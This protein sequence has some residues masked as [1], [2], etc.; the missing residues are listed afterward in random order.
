[1]GAFTPFKRR[2]NDFKYTP[3]YY[4]PAKE[5]REER[6]EEMFGRRSDDGGEGGYQPGQYIRRQREARSAR[7]KSNNKNST[8]KM[9][10]SVA[11]VLVVAYMGSMLYN[12]LVEMFGLTE[13]TSPRT[14][15]TVSEYDEFDP[16][17]PITIVP[18][19][20]EEE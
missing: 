3:R 1:M 15:Q 9:W 4:D 18:N 7:N 8:M 10:I 14:E 19:D 13:N 17:A 2:A 12:K 6:R 5:A 16:T 20:Y 11:V